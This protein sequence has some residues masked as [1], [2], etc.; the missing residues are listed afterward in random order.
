MEEDLFLT[1]EQ[2]RRWDFVLADEVKRT[3][4]TALPM[5]AVLVSQNLLEVSSIM[6]V[7]HRSELELATTAI[8]TSL[9]NVTGFSLLVF[10]LASGLETL[11][12][13]AYGAG[14]YVKA[15]V[16]KLE[17]GAVGAALAIRISYT[18]NVILLGVYLYY[19]KECEKTRLTCSV[20]FYS[21]IKEFIRF[22]IPSAIRI[23][24]AWSS[25][26]ILVL[27]E[28]LLLNPQLETSVLAICLTM[29][30][31]HYYIPYSFGVAARISNELGAGNPEAAKTA[32][33]VASAVG[34]VFLPPHES[35]SILHL[36]QVTGVSG[37][38]G[39]K[40]NVAENK[41]VKESMKANL[42]KLL[43]YNALSTRVKKFEVKDYDFKIASVNRKF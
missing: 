16:F 36:S 37:Q 22:T 20:D 33:L 15:L 34:V 6:M 1:T 28:G 42:G 27:L 12:G 35:G 19:L 2:S 3:C 17:L 7:G 4:Y 23:C 31:S 5:V 30:M 38:E 11:C 8:A 32:L 40:G 24:L 41:K 29:D 26:E 10:G 13:Q 14:Q 21:N 25:Y 39:A 9:T 43:K 18:L